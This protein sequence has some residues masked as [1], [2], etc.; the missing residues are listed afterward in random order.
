MRKKLRKENGI[1]LIALVIT[2]IVLLILVAVSIA[3]LTGENGILT[4]AQN[5]KVLNQISQIKEEIELYR[6]GKYIEEK[7]GIEAYP[8][9]TNEA[10]ERLTIK[11]ILSQEELNN[12]PENLRYEMLSMTT[13]STGTQIPSLD[14]LDYDQFYKLDTDT[15]ISAGEW[16]DRLVIWVN[17]DDY[18]VIHV[19]GVT[20]Q[21]E[22]VYIIIPLNNEKEPEYITTSNNTFKFYGDGTVKVVG[23]KNSLSGITSEENSQINGV[24]ELD[25]E[26]I[27]EQFGN[28]MALP[29]KKMYISRGTIYII[30]QNDDLWAWGDNSYNKLGQGNS[31]LVTEPTKILE[32]RTEG[33]EGVKAKDVWA[34]YSN[35]V[36]LDTQNR[37]WICGTNNNGELGQGDYQIRENYVQITNIP[38]N[39]IE[40]VYI[41]IGSQVNN[42]FFIYQDGNVYL[43][44]N[45]SH[46]AL[47]IGNNTTQTRYIKLSDYSDIKNVKK[48]TSAGTQAFLLTKEGILYASGYNGNG[49]LG[50]GDTTNRKVWTKLAE[51]I[52]DVEEYSQSGSIISIDNQGNIYTVNNKKFTK[53]T[54][55]EPSAENKMLSAGMISQNN[56]IYY[57]NGGITLSKLEGNYSNIEGIDS[58]FTKGFKSNGK[59]Y[60]KDEPRITKPKEMSINNLKTVF[61]NAIFVQG[62]GNNLN[63]VDKNGQIYENFVKN[64]E[65]S[66]VKKIIASNTSKY[67]ITN[68][69]KLYAKG[70]PYTGMWGELVAKNNYVEIN[71][72]ENLG[73]I[74]EIY[75]SST[76]YGAAFITKDNKLYYAGARSFMQLPNLIGD[77]TIPDIGQVTLYPKEINS[78]N[79]ERIKGKIKDIKYNFTNTGGIWGSNTN[80]ITENGELYVM[81]YDKNMSG[82]GKITTDIEQLVIKEGTTVE[83]VET[84]GGLTLAVLS[85]GEIYGWGY[86]TYGILGDGYE[87][88]GVYPIPV[89]LNLPNNIKSV[90]L[91]TGFAIFTSKTG[92]VYGIGRNDYGQ[93]GTGDNKGASTFVRCPELE[94]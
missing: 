33:I 92:E 42:I 35:T 41:S 75:T 45:N 40:E 94:K 7:T 36:V 26:A 81:A 29:E 16:K 55:L 12:L 52:E 2:I 6:T 71:G 31:F 67:C 46:G 9:E 82:N 87:V 73:E 5:A 78:E 32:G 74:K 44:G 38:T 39:E 58:I 91:G 90:S 86:N 53:V 23:Q 18:K 66:N 10:G 93:L 56:N 83:E 4:Q 14:Q 72:N 77:I 89:K 11:D 60:V 27:N 49:K 28:P 24:Q 57:L 47:G 43:A 25:I 3:M 80:I 8:I 48:I 30:D 37:I 84:V 20:Y 22:K 13:E 50:F 68:D 65:L 1:T 19:D 63:I 21:K 15:I 88:G 17:G 85:N 79:L 70:S 59:I 69:N 51:N 76:G 54:E 64:T 61:E 34:G 62:N